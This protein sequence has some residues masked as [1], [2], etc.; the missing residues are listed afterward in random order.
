MLTK[1]IVDDAYCQGVTFTVSDT[2]A[3]A[4]S[5]ALVLIQEFA[6]AKSLLPGGTSGL[7]ELSEAGGLPLGDIEDIIARRLKPAVVY[8][9]DGLLFQ[10]VMWL[11]AHLDLEPGDLVAPPHSHGSGKGQD[12]IVVHRVDGSVAALSIC[13]DKATKNPEK[14]VQDKVWPEIRQYEAGGR[15]DELRSNVITTLG[16]ARVPQEEAARLIRGI[17]WDGKRRYRVRVTVEKERNETLFEGFDEIVAGRSE[18]RRGESTHLPQMRAW[19]TGF[20]A[21]VEAH[22]RRYV[23]ED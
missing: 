7:E 19:M 6:I 2:E 18:M 16:T 3:L 21:R 9:R 1:G 11:A 12:S 13:E 4:H 5:V 8:H 17:S 10:H 15:R 20:A 23:K 22:L 14:T